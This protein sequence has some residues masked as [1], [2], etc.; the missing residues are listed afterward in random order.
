MVSE[1]LQVELDPSSPTARLQR[2]NESAANNEGGK[3][4]TPE[5]FVARL[6]NQGYEERPA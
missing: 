4:R 1:R 2:L 6:S 5:R 3:I